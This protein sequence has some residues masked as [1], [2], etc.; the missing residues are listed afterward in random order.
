ML[1]THD[2][3]GQQV[4]VIAEYANRRLC[5]SAMHFRP[6]A[7]FVLANLSHNGPNQSMSSYHLSIARSCW[8]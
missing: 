6:K 8:F 7:T 5:R 1:V 2:A 4:H 3:L